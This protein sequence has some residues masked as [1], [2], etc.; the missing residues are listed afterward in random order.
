MNRPLYAAYMGCTSWASVRL[1]L[2]KLEALQPLPRFSAIHV[3]QERR[4]ANASIAPMIASACNR[5]RYPLDR[6][7]VA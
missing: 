1:D 7:I 3:R 2:P 6:L 5:S 4:D